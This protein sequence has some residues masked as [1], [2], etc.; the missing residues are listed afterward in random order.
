MTD[1][2]SQMEPAKQ[3]TEFVVYLVR[4]NKGADRNI[5]PPGLSDPSVM[6]S[7]FFLL[8]S[9]LQPYMEGRPGLEGSLASF[10]AGAM[11][12]GVR[13]LILV[14]SGS[15]DSPDLQRAPYAQLSGKHKI[16]KLMPFECGCL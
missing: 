9:L 6:S 16:L 13:A 4:K 7:A 14:V 3:L 10:P 1:A 11:F 8:L 2:G 5:P 12:L 15:L